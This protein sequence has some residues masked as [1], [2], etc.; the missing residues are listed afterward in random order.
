MDLAPGARAPLHPS[1]LVNSLT[2]LKLMHKLDK[3]IL[4][5]RYHTCSLEDLNHSTRGND[6][7]QDL[8]T[9]LKLDQFV[10][11][12]L[13]D[14]ITTQHL[15]NRPTSSCS[16]YNIKEEFVDL[17]GETD[18][19]VSPAALPADPPKVSPT[20]L[21]DQDDG[22]LDAVCTSEGAI[23]APTV[24][25]ELGG[26][27]GGERL[28]DKPHPR[29]PSRKTIKVALKST[30]SS[31]PPARSLCSIHGKARAPHN[32]RLEKG[33]WVCRSGSICALGKADLALRKNKKET[34]DKPDLEQTKSVLS[35]EEI[36]RHISRESRKGRYTNAGSGFFALSD[37]MPWAS[38]QGLTRKNILS[39][40]KDMLFQQLS[41][42]RGSILRFN[43]EQDVARKEVFI[44]VSP[45]CSSKEF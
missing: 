13:K 15:R 27:L 22:S 29:S 20:P 26:G 23:E 8:A 9:F 28:S 43:L 3:A 34:R 42:S 10:A 44:R 11:E 32:L 16:A 37:V 4:W 24:K 2:K 7:L 18:H 19:C 45:S 12:E 6:R 40:I 5:L 30:S 31:G 38:S 21:K 25:A 41:D 35:N 33:E 17:S 14:A 39:A 1:W 36:C